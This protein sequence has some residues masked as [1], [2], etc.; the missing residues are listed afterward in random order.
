MYVYIIFSEHNN[1]SKVYIFLEIIHSFQDMQTK[2]QFHRIL[3]YKLV[4]STNITDIRKL[5]TIDK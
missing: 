1:N 4:T 2:C 3:N 5:I